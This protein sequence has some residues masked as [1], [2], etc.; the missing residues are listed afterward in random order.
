[1]RAL[2][3]IAIIATTAPAFAQDTPDCGSGQ[4]PCIQ[5][6]QPTTIY[7]SEVC[8][9]VVHRSAQAI[10][11]VCHREYDGPQFSTASKEARKRSIEICERRE[12][13]LDANGR[14]RP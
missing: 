10:A 1:M 11:D 12:S 6:E 8:G 5:R 7:Q 3:A 4:W 9:S 2:I 13:I 14:G